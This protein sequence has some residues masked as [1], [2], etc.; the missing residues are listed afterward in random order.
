LAFPAPD[1]GV[2]VTVHEEVVR[3]AG[4]RL[5]VN[6]ENVPVTPAP[7]EKVEVPVGEP[8]F[9]VGAASVTDATQVVETPTLTEFGLQTTETFVLS[10]VTVKRKSGLLPA[11]FQ[12]AA[13]DEV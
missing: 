8:L 5:Q 12:L 1:V 11:F 2:K 6:A 13:L 4:T 9:G 10:L 7:S 3:V